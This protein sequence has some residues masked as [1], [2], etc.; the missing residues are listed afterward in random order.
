MHKEST[1]SDRRFA[2]CYGGHNPTVESLI[3]E[4][5]QT[6]L[7]VG[8]GAGDMA[9]WLS[10]RGVQVDGISW[11]EE[12][13]RA[14]TQF[15]RETWQVDLN[16]TTPDLAA[17]SYDLIICSH[18][19]EHIAYPDSLLR[20]IF[21]ALKPGGYFVVAIP[22]VMFWRDRFKLLRGRWNYESSG[23]FD[24]THLRWYTRESMTTLLQQ[25]GFTIE[26][27]VAD[28]WIP[29]PGLKLV[30][31]KNCRASINRWAARRWPEMFGHQFIFRCIK[32]GGGT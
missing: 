7:D 3:P 17:D 4:K 9:A 23:T 10:Q 27:F 16:K 21:R 32:K 11:N 13:L 24:Y 18:L 25:H 22:N 2:T 26:K 5:I 6:A 20:A 8:C 14:A 30:V 1:T 28:G 29:I 31:T 15:C 12:E 19:L